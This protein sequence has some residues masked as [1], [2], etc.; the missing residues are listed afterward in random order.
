MYECSVFKS[1]RH[2]TIDAKHTAP[3]GK[4]KPC[5]E[6]SHFKTEY[7]VKPCFQFPERPATWNSL[8]LEFSQPGP[9][10]GKCKDNEDRQRECRGAGCSSYFTLAI[11]YWNFETKFENDF[12]MSR[13]LSSF[14]P[15]L[16][17][18]VW[19]S[20]SSSQCVKHCCANSMF[21]H[22]K[23]VLKGLKSMS[24]FPR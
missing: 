7:I 24:E 23:F 13:L 17:N 2:L 20:W 5:L 14:H 21:W 1:K 22:C 12:H 11:I 4:C 8:H 10:D 18:W 15:K 16:R 19:I 9:G 6:N 3:W